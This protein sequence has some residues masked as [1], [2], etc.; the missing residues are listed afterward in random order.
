[1]AAAIGAIHANQRRAG[2]R[3]QGR[4]VDHHDVA[5]SRE[6]VDRFCG[7]CGGAERDL[8]QSMSGYGPHALIGRLTT[9]LERAAG[10]VDTDDLNGVDHDDLAA[11][12]G[13][14]LALV[15]AWTEAQ[16]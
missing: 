6:R 15:A 10:L 11:T 8:E 4:A 12:I 5:L 16:R 3:W 1:M 7:R 14:G 13:R 2:Q 9:V